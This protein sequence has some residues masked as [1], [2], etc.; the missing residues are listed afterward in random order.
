MATFEN[1]FIAFS[2][3]GDIK[4]DGTF[5]TLVQ[6]DKWMKQAHVLDKNITEM[7]AAIHFNKFKFIY[8]S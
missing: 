2:K 6:S 4:S 5:I 8:N 3:Y 7:D 1:Q